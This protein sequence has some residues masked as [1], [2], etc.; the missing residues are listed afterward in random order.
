MRMIQAQWQ[1]CEG[2]KAL[3]EGLPRGWDALISLPRHLGATSSLSVV[4]RI[5]DKVKNGKKKKK[6]K[7]VLQNSESTKTN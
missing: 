6:D 2:S 5:H 7:A 4:D 1:W 3:H